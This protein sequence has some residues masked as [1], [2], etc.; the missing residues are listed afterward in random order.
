MLIAVVPLLL[1]AGY[2]SAQTGGLLPCDGPS[3]TPDSIFT[4]I[5]NVIDFLLK[6]VIPLGA[7]GFAI[8]GFFIMFS[9]G[10]EGRVATGKQMMWGVIGGMILMI[11]AYVVVKTLLNVLA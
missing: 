9:G 2:V 6:L 1:S 10:N 4:V 8:A 5:D 3:C 7:I 11:F